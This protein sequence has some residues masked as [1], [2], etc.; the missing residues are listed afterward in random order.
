MSNW[1]EHSVSN[2]N[3]S[4]FQ[5]YDIGNP[6]VTSAW[7]GWDSTGKV[8][9]A[10]ITGANATYDSSWSRFW[11]PDT[12][13]SVAWSVTFTDYTYSFTATF[14]QPAAIDS[15]GWLSNTVAPDSITGTFTGQ[16]VPTVDYLKNPIIDGDT[17]G[18]NIGFS[19]ALFVDLDG[20]AEPMNYYG[21]PVPAPGAI[22]L[23]MMGTG[24]VGWLRRRRS[25]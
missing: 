14:S 6:S 3:N 22:L 20:G 12:T 5:L 17:Y 8:F 18:F 23:G 9:T 16:F 21:A 25:L 7:G 19:K 13:N 4:F 15:D 1:A 24:L 2:Q 10:T 11:Q